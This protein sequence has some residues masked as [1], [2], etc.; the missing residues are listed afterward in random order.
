[1]E[2]DRIKMAGPHQKP[3]RSVTLVGCV[4]C[5]QSVNDRLCG[6]GQ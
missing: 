2:I 1:M 6:E 5:Y 4:L 3:G